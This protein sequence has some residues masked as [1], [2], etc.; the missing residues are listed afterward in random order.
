[1]NIR[2]N[3][4]LR[5]KVIRR[6]QAGLFEEIAHL[7]IFGGGGGVQYIWRLRKCSSSSRQ[8]PA[9]RRNS[10]LIPPH[11]GWDFGFQRRDRDPDF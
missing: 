9:L 2:K 3:S 11:Q 5:K 8:K 4:A 1:M 10:P 7:L 6:T